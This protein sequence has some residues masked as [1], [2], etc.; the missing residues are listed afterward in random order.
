MAMPAGAAEH[1]GGRL[2]GRGGRC[3]AET[4]ARRDPDG[5]LAISTVT[6]VDSG[7]ASARPA[8][9][10]LVDH[11]LGGTITPSVRSGEPVP[12]CVRIPIAFQTR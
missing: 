5:R 9:K 4:G 8:R 11:D 10:D 12:F 7:A 6:I 2:G 3:Q 1:P